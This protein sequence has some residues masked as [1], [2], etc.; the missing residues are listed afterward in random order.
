MQQK[1]QAQQVVQ[2]VKQADQDEQDEH[3]GAAGLE[4]VGHV[5]TQEAAQAAH[6]SAWARFTVQVAAC[7]GALFWIGALVA[8]IAAWPTGQITLTHDFNHFGEYHFET[9]VVAPIMAAVCVFG[10]LYGVR[11][12]T[13]GASA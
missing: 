9:F 6:A 8:L 7:F 12:D 1:Q 5:E 2:E 10:F 13:R 11:R 4:F 3:A